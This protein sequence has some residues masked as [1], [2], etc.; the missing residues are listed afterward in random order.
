MH[1]GTEQHSTAQHTAEQ[2][3]AGERNTQAH[4]ADKGAQMISAYNSHWRAPGAWTL[5]PA[6]GSLAA[7]RCIGGYRGLAPVEE[8]GRGPCSRGRHSLLM[9]RSTQRSTAGQSRQ[10][11]TTEQSSTVHTRAAQDS[12][13]SRCTEEQRGAVHIRGARA[14][15]GNTAQHTAQQRKAEQSRAPRQRWGTATARP[16]NTNTSPTPDTRGGC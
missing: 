8:L 1:N 12:A 13:T 10:R 3:S 15:K 6:Y 16:T 2:R 14:Y 4:R 11:C 9:Q 7:S 5:C